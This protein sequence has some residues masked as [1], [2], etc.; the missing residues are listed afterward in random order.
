MKTVSKETQ[1]LQLQ[2]SSR[3]A[4]AVEGISYLFIHV[5]WVTRVF[6]SSVWGF[7]YV[8]ALSLNDK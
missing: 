3:L 5:A 7:D 6:M 2:S 4:E 8:L 1:T